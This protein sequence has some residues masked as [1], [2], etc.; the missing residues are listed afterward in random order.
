V[1]EVRHRKRKALTPETAKAQ[2]IDHQKPKAGK[3][4]A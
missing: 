2:K 4:K 1:E 3:K